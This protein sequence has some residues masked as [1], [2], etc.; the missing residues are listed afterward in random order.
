[1]IPDVSKVMPL[2]HDEPTK[3]CSRIANRL[4]PE[5]QQHSLDRFCLS[6]YA[7]M[8]CLVLRSGL[9]F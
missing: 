1:M 4:H 5:D 9:A 3:L 7:A 8:I 6:G 2:A